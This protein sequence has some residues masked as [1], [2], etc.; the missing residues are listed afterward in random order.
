MHC[1]RC[2]NNGVVLKPLGG[3]ITLFIAQKWALKCISCSHVW[4][5][6]GNLPVDP[7]YGFHFGESAEAPPKRKLLKEAIK[8][9]N[10]P[11]ELIRNLK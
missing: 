1:H 9:A 8:E 6:Y 4:V 3:L 10:T 2:G 7:K 5:S 11:L